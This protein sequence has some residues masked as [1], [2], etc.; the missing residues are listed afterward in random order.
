VPVIV[1][2]GIVAGVGT[3]TEASSFAVV[4]GLLVALF[5]YRTASTATVWA[6]LR[7][8]SLIGGIVLMVLASSNLMTQAI[9]YDGVPQHLS[10]LLTAAG[11]KGAFLFIVGG[12]LIVLGIV[13]EGLP[14]LIIFAPLLLPIA[15]K[16]GVHPLHFGIVIIMGMGIG[17]FAPPFGIGIYQACIIGGAPLEKVFRPSL[18]YTAMLIVGLVFVIAFPEITLFVPRLFGL[19]Q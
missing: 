2:G 18:F 15:E 7:E 16:L 4:Y 3:P 6:L 12:G 11:G 13:L 8:A 17:V 14:A 19:G 5:V 9:V 10:A 1:I